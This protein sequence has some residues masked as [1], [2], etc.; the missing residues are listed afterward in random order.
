ME[1]EWMEDK[2]VLDPTVVLIYALIVD[3]IAEML[4]TQVHWCK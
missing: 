1:E 4:T 3:S 2:E